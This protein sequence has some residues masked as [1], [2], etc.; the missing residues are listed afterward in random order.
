LGVRA[1]ASDLEGFDS[2]VVASGV[3]PRTPDIEGINHEKVVSYLDVLEGRVAVGARVAIIGAGGIGF[4]IAEFLSHA[5]VTACDAVEPRWPNVESFSRHWGIDLEYRSRGGVQGVEG[6]P[7][8][9]PR[10][11]WM[12]QRK[13]T[14]PGKSLGK[15]TG[16]IHRRELNMRGVKTLA[17]VTYRRIDNFGLH[18]D[19]GGRDKLLEVDHVVVCAGQLPQ[20][21]LAEALTGAGIDFHLIG[22]ADEAVEL[23]AKRAIRQAS[24]LAA[25]L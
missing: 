16:W 19:L 11:I 7:E 3:V 12:L 24:E 20:R 13:S 18:I 10:Q 4:D 23:D 6:D 21:D 8:P 17:G 15:T 1:R 14:R 9:S 2:V 5:E 25:R 22:G